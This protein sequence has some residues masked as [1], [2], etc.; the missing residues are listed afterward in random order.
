MGEANP[1]FKPGQ[2]ITLNAGATITGGL[3]QR[4]RHGAAPHQPDRE[5]QQADDRGWQHRQ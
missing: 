3:L 4:L 2:D 1:K 5:Q